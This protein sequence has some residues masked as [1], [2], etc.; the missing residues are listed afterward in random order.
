MSIRDTERSISYAKEWIVTQRL[1]REK[2][3]QEEKEYQLQMYTDKPIKPVKIRK[4]H[5]KTKNVNI[6]SLFASDSDE[7]VK[8][9]PEIKPEIK[10]PKIPKMCWADECE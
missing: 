1:E 4:K 2:D 5:K 6:Y 9:T 8:L 3:E 7:E 10:P